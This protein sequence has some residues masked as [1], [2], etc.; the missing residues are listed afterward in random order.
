MA[1]PTGP[2]VTF[3]FTDIEGSTRLERAV[4]SAAWAHDRSPPRRAPAR[5][6]RGRT[7]ASSSRPRATRSSRPST[8]PRRG[9]GR[10]RG[11]A[12]RSR[13]SPGRPMRRSAV[14]MGLHLGEGRLRHGRAPGD[15]ED[16]VGIDV[17][18]AARI[19]AAGNGGQIVLSQALVEALAARAAASTADRRRRSPTR[20]CERSR[21]SRSRCGS[22]GSSSRA[23]PTTTAPLRT[24][25]PPIEPAG[26]GHRARRPR[27]R[28]RRA[29][30]GARRQPDRDPDRPRRERQDAARARRRPVRSRP[31]PAWRLVRRP[32]GGAR[33]GAPRVVD[34]PDARASAS[35][36]PRRSGRRSAATFA[37]G[38]CSWC[39][40]TSSSC[41]PT[42]RE[43]VAGLVRGAPEPAAA[44]DEPRAAP[45]RR[46]AGPP[47]AAAGRRGRRRAVRGSRPSPLRPDLVAR[48]TRP[49]RRS[50]RSASASTACRSR[51]SWPRR[52]SGCSARRDPR[53]AVEQPRPRRRRPRPARAAAHAARRDRLE[54]RPPR[55]AGAAPL[56]PARGVRR[57]LD[58]GRRRTPWRT[59][60]ATSGWT[61]SDG[62]ES[63]AD[64]SLVRI[65]PADGRWRATTR[66]ASASTRSSAN[67]PS[68]ASTRAASGRPRGASCRGDRRDRGD[69]RRPDPRAGRRAEHSP[70]RSR[71]STTSA[72]RSTGPLANDDAGAGPPAHGRRPG[73]GSSSA[74]ACARAGRC[75]PSSFAPTQGPILRI[76]IAGLAA[77]GGL[78]YWMNDVP[79]APGGLPGAARARRRRLG[80]PV[81]LADAHYD[82]GFLS[83]IAKDARGSCASTSSRPSTCT[84]RRAARTARSGPARPS[85]SA[86][87]WPATTRRPELRAAEPRRV[88]RR[89]DRSPDRRQH[90]RSWRPSTIGSAIS[91]RSCTGYPRASDGS[92]CRTTRRSGPGPDGRDPPARRGPARAR[93]ADHRHDDPARGGAGRDARAGEV[94][95]L[96]H[97]R[98]LAIE[99][100]PRREP[101]S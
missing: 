9:R 47:G 93:G 81:L 27:R 50:A 68:S 6:D 63:L 28:D 99:R 4:G 100:L 43:T 44:G 38:P 51:S 55:R 73:A 10:G 96:P 72:P 86:S 74:A 82:L 52:A 59:P 77:A 40:T 60:T 49:A 15:P 88:S 57:R 20:G 84:W 64:K 78:A 54:P 12:R 94:L 34:R 2:A 24:L 92:D 21:T 98:D 31:L 33:P 90:A 45:D 76:R 53:A 11:P 61:C 48:P 46:R 97:P 66:P 58:A 101:P 70:P 65:E 5:R 75:S 26:R 3:L 36:R 32:G 29:P 67:T 23:P 56:P 83:M 1:L 89:P 25:E 17:N 30:R 13:P 14:R 16:Y 87:S 71:G 79:A 35:R 69:G 37:T 91:R 85:S 41:C 42:R 8:S 22:T 39:S 80:D 95:H 7:A 18:Y 62:L 19:A